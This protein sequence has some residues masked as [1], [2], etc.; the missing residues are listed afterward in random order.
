MTNV[1]VKSNEQ[2]VARF[3]SVMTRKGR[4]NFKRLFTLAIMSILALSAWADVD[5]TGRTA[6]NELFRLERQ[7][8]HA[9]YFI[10]SGSF[11]KSIDLGATGSGEGNELTNT[12]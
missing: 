5:I 4:I 7:G 11:L 8:D 3:N 10:S 12:W 1:F 9:K 6:T 2:N